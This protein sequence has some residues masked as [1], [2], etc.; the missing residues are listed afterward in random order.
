MENKPIRILHMIG[1]LDVGGSQAIVMNLYRHIDRSK[2]QFDFVLDHPKERFFEQ[3]IISLGGK[4]YNMPSF[5]GKNLLFLIKQ[6]TLFFQEHPEYHV[7]HSHIRSYAIIYLLVAKKF[8]LKTIIHSHSTSNGRGLKSLSKIILQYP[9][10]FICNHYFACSKEAGRWLFGKKIV[11]SPKFTV[12]SNA[13]D[14]KK[15]TFNAL[16]R[17]QIRAS[18]EINP[19]TVVYGHVGRLH[20]SKNHLFLI[21]VFAAISSR[22]ANSVLLLVGEGGLRSEICQHISEKGLDDT[23]IMVGARDDISTLL[24]A[25][26]CFIFP[27]KW[28][29][30]AISVLEAQAAGLPSFISSVIP[31]AVNLTELVRTLDL[32]LSPSQWAEY[33]LK[34]KNTRKDY[35]L[36]LIS[37]GYDIGNLALWMKYFYINI[38]S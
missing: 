28:E 23:V 6:W 37:K 30:F 27:S 1:G 5:N 4:I 9:L 29:G 14:V 16:L 38:N 7:I 18:L 17:E 33:I 20:P 19:E 3:E 2:V 24:Q 34:H 31:P 25:F 36:D 35:S 22:Q 32:S 13:I 12:L 11:D 8:H 15:F 21:D 26:D 10:R